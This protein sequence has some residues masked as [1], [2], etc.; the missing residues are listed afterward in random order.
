MIYRPGENNDFIKKIQIE[1]NRWI[2]ETKQDIRLLKEDG[3]F[4]IMTHRVIQIFQANHN[5]TIDGI[6]GPQTLGILGLL[7]SDCD[8][9]ESHI[10]E[11]SLQK[12]FKTENKKKWI[13]LHHTAGWENP[14]NVVDYWNNNISNIGTEYVIGGL[15]IQKGDTGF[16]GKILK[17][18]PDNG[19][20]WHLGIGNRKMH[21][22]SIGIELCSFGQLE[23][24]D[25]DYITWTK[26]KVDPSQILIL[27]NKFRGFNFFH[28]YSDTQIEA[29]KNLLIHLANKHNIDIKRGL[30]ELIHKKGAQALDE[31]SIKMCENT[32]GVW[33]HTNV[34]TKGKWDIQPQPEMLDMLTEL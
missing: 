27:N 6:V 23:Y 28:K 10:E 22:D 13:F 34:V 8:N 15:N 4:G 26:R 9:I 33:S 29:T 3:L 1:L 14:Y 17:C 16:D 18:L 32:P 5:L 31:V 24:R 7:D 25:P 12:Y 19:Y 30:P 21:R 11:Y 20:L 2:K